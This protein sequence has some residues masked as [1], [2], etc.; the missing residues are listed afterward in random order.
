MVFFR[1]DGVKLPHRLRVVIL[2][3]RMALG[4]DLFYLGWTINFDPTAAGKISA[5]SLGSLYAWLTGG[6]WNGLGPVFTWITIVAG[7]CLMIGL[8]MRTA[9]VVALALAIIGFLPN[10]RA[11]TLGVST[12]LHN[13]VVFMIGL[14]VLIFA[15]AGTYL[16]LDRFIHI[17]LFGKK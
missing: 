2:F 9:A 13:E 12:L 8:F 15:N 16:G 7:I 4:L 11:G 6:S 1:N 14:L 17:R 5:Y 10:L 3:L